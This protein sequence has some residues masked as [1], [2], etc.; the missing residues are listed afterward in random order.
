MK[1]NL[2]NFSNWI[3]LIF[4]FFPEFAFTLVWCSGYK[5]DST[6]LPSSP[7][8]TRLK[9]AKGQMICRL[10]SSSQ[11]HMDIFNFRT[12]TSWQVKLLKGLQLR[13]LVQLQKDKLKNANTPEAAWEI[14][15]VPRKVNLSD[16]TILTSLSHFFQRFSEQIWS[17]FFSQLLA[18]QDL[19]WLVASLG[20][21]LVSHGKTFSRALQRLRGQK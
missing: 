11:I 6:A 19:F 12:R 13:G 4:T 1:A 7:L 15:K 16:V 20:I 10:H 2:T 17:V 3:V 14:V 18:Y 5:L 8:A 21:S 9:E